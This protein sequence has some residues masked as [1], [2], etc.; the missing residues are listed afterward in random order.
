M[1]AL[2]DRVFWLPFCFVLFCFV[3]FPFSDLNMPSHSF[4]ACKVSA[5]KS[6]DSPLD[7]PCIQLFTFLFLLLEFSVATFCRFTYLSWC[8]DPWVIFLGGSHFFLDLDVCYLPQI[9]EIFS[10]YFFKWILCPLSI[11]SSRIGIIWML[12]FIV[13][14][15]PLNLFYYSLFLFPLQLDC[16]SLFCPP[17]TWSFLLPLVYYLFLP[18]YFQ[19]QLLSS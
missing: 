10:Y 17:S 12:H 5:E 16:F 13:S 18:V 19:F 1:I 15:S 4:L 11:S 8:G 3:L 2:L 6:A 9:R 14:L 7:F